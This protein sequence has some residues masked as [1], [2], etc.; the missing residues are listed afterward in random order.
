MPIIL[1]DHQ[2]TKEIEK[3]KVLK[4]YMERHLYLWFNPH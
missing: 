3:K 1:F 2:K 4:T